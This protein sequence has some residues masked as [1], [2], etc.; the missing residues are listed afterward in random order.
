MCPAGGGS[1]SVGC[2]RSNHGQSAINSTMSRTTRLRHLLFSP[3]LLLSIGCTPKLPPPETSSPTP[4]AISIPSA[5]EVPQPK[6]DPQKYSTM[7]TALNSFGQRLFTEV[8]KSGE[9]NLA[10]SPVG[11]FVLLELLREG[12]EGETKTELTKLL[13]GEEWSSAEAANLVWVLNQS[14]SLSVAQKVFVDSSTE[15]RSEYLEALDP[16]LTGNVEPVSF[17]TDSDNA[18]KRITDWTSE[19]TGGLLDAK[20]PLRE[21]TLCVLLSALL[22]Q[23][24][25]FHEFEPADTKDKTFT[26]TDGTEIQVP[27]MWLDFKELDYYR[28][29]EIQAVALPYEDDME[30][31]LIL[32]K[33]GSSA[34]GALSSLDFSAPPEDGDIRVTLDL[35][36]F[37][38]KTPELDLTDA[39]KALGA[40]TLVDGA[41]LSRL[42]GSSEAR[43]MGVRTFQQA[44]VRVNEAGT[45]AAAVTEISASPA[46]TETP[47]DDLPKEIEL[48]FDHPFA[49]AL[50]HRPSRALV[51]LG[52][53]ERP[54]Q[55]NFPPS[56]PSPR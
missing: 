53:V 14:P 34:A 25:W 5:A 19:Q 33:K 42:L 36:R 23:G 38:V 6:F 21:D 49:F 35:P 50:R 26:C 10:V 16:S 17:K 11:P 32:P 56:S 2:Q 28:Q 52:T 41:D 45:V 44:L 55:S 7:T 4:A 27:T 40:D 29:G 39:L 12:A 54:D 43:M 15:I 18:Q 48:H 8:A 22:Y 46:S 51:F 24:A 31:L 9:G 30:M 1:V 3:L 13:G 37:E 47:S 20:I